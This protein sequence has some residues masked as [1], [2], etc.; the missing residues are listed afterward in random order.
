[1][2]EVPTTSNFEPRGKVYCIWCESFG[3]ACPKLQ[4]YNPHQT[5]DISP[6]LSSEALPPPEPLT[7]K[8]LPSEL[9]VGFQ[10]RTSLDIH[11]T[12]GYTV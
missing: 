9:E 4:I 8:K 6:S 5:L 12:H 1:M 7:K 2:I 11:L 3:I 10:P